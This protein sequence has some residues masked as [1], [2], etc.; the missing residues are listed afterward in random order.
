M[1]KCSDA[2]GQLTQAAS[3]VQVSDLS[4]EVS[5]AQI[6]CENTGLNWAYGYLGSVLERNG[7]DDGVY[8]E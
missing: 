8:K 4:T 5:L 6:N 2:L 1:K 7:Q 3:D